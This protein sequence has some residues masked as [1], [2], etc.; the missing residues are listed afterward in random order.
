[1][2]ALRQEEGRTCLAVS[3]RRGTLELASW[4]VVM[5]EGRIDAQ[6]RLEEVLDRSE[7]MRSLWGR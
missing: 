3:H 7:E 6:C 2:E 1:V 4:V 5:R